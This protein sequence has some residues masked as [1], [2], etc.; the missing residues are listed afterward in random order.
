VNKLDRG[1]AKL[2][3]FGFTTTNKTKVIGGKPAWMAP[4]LFEKD[5]INTTACDIYS[6][7]IHPSHI[8]AEYET[9]TFF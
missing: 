8:C 2:V 3:D 1:L 5:P 4:E 7:G 6:F 9:E